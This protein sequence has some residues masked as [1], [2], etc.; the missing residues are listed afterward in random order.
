MRSIT[1]CS[2]AVVEAAFHEG[3][4]WFCAYPPIHTQ[5]HTLSLSLSLCLLPAVLI[6][7]VNGV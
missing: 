4:L 2:V 5:S 1:R 6:S 7:S 3:R